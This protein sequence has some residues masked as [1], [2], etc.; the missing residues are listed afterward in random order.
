MGL[1]YIILL[2]QNQGS[3]KKTV[4]HHTLT[5]FNSKSVKNPYFVIYFQCEKLTGNEIFLVGIFQ[6]TYSH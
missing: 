4:M 2:R 1:Y 6:F 5:Y 3:H